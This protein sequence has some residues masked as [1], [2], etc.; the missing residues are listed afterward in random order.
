MSVDDI[1][2]QTKFMALFTSGSL[3]TW[4]EPLDT[5]SGVSPRYLSTIYSQLTTSPFLYRHPTMTEYAFFSHGVDRWRKE[6]ALMW[7]IIDICPSLQQ[8][9]IPSHTPAELSSLSSLRAWGER[10]KVHHNITFL[11]VLA[12]KEAT[13]EGNMVCR[14]YW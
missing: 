7:R 9:H 4:G 2:T 3:L 14:P 6:M 11:L 10:Q 12:K 13:G 8:F 5:S 1:N